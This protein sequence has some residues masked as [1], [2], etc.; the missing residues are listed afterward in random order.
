METIPPP[1]PNSPAKLDTLCSLGTQVQSRGSS[2]QPG[3]RGEHQSEPGA[4]PAA[5]HAGGAAQ[6]RP[7][8]H[9]VRAQSRGDLRAGGPVHRGGDT[10]QQRRVAEF[11]GVPP[12]TRREGATQGLRQVQGRPG[13]GA[14]S[15]RA[16]LGLHELAGHRDYVSR[17]DAAALRE[18]RSTEGWYGVYILYSLVARLCAAARASVALHPRVGR[19]IRCSWNLLM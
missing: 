5:R 9:Q 18:T 1:S 12:D 6:A 10:R 17:V 13:H 15:H 8:L 7:G 14:R 11:R 16:L 2:P 4:R 19:M 3:Q